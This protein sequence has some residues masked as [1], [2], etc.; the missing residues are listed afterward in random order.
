M[1]QLTFNDR[2]F[3]VDDDESVLDVLLRH[4]QDIP[5]SCRKGTCHTCCMKAEQGEIPDTAQRGLKETEKAQGFFLACSCMPSTDMVISL[6]SDILGNHETTVIE[7]DI[8]PGDVIRLRLKPNDDFEYQAGQFINLMKDEH[9]MRSYSLASVPGQDDFLELHIKWV[10]DG[11]VSTWVRDV[12]N[13]NDTV[14]I[15]NA[16]GNSFYLPGKPEQALLLIGTGTGLSPLL[17]VARAALAAGHTG[18]IHL[19]HGSR[20]AEGLYLDDDLRAMNKQFSNF[21][22]HACISGEHTSPNAAS[23]RANELAL[24]QFADL[25]GWRVFLCGNPQMVDK[26]KLKAYL[27]GASLAEILTDPFLPAQP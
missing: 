16:I 13:I 1:P 12:L 17:G 22:Y 5:H 21:T 26:T 8:L 9:T 15:S 24:Q 11:R 14:H 10:A 18:D 25:K 7:K 3:D 4:G 23:G 2:V 27:A 19:F 6:P 20:T